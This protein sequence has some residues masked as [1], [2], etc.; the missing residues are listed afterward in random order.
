MFMMPGLWGFAAVKNRQVGQE[1]FK[2]ITNPNKVF[3]I[4]NLFPIVQKNHTSHDSFLCDRFGG[5][6]FPSKRT[7]E[8]CYSGGYGCCQSSP[9]IDYYSRQFK[10]KCSAICRPQDHPDWSYC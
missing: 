7:P 9:E 6:P 2:M 1:M 3:D 8:Y 5:R 4:K 10:T